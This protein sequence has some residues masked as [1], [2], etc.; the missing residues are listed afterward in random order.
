MNHYQE[1]EEFIVEQFDVTFK[2]EKI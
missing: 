1:I 2:V